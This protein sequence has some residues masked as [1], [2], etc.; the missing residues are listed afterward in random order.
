MASQINVGIVDDHKIVRNGLK[1]LLEMNDAFKVSVEFENGLRFVKEVAYLKQIPDVFLLDYSMPIMNG[2][3]VLQELKAQDSGLKCIVLTQHNDQNIKVDAYE[4][5]A[6]GFLSKTCDLEHLV[7][8][9]TRVHNQGYDNFEEILKLL[10]NKKTVEDLGNEAREQLTDREMTLIEL[11][12]D[13]AEFTY[14]QIADRMNLSIKSVDA[15]RSQLFQKLDV[16]SKVG[17]VLHSYNHKLTSPFLD[18]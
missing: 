14:Q 10:R 6:R 7:A 15:C 17:L 9:I 3:Q 4:A 16:R 13:E 18:A 11:V 5:G 1:Q 12:C 2:L 8:T